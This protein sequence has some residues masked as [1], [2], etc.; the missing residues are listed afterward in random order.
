MPLGLS[1]VAGTEIVPC[2]CL[3]CVA[4]IAMLPVCL[5]GM[6]QISYWKQFE[7]GIL[8]RD[9]I[10]KLVDLVDVAT[11]QTSHLIDRDEIRKTWH[12]RGVYDYI[13]STHA[14]CV[15]THACAGSRAREKTDAR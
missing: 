6:F 13:V 5:S 11:D 7:H 1:G 12:V 2:L 10:R 9:G 8:S 15:D 14:P 3:S 4:G